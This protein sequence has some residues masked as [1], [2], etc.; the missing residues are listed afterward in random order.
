M[1]TSSHPLFGW[2][3][4]RWPWISL[5]LVGLGA[6]LLGIALG[7]SD[8]P[9]DSRAAADAA[10][11]AAEQTLWTCSM[12]PQVR[13]SQP[14]KCPI[15]GM[16]LIRA[17][18]EQEGT[19]T[20]PR[21]ITLSERAKTLARIRTTEARRRG[22]EGQQQQLS[23]RVTYDETRLKTV[24]AW[25][26]GRIDRLHVEVTG[27][28]V[29]AGQVIATLYSPE[30]YAAH[31]DLL[32]TK[33][34][35][36]AMQS[37]NADGAA[38]AESALGA[39]RKRLALLGVPSQTIDRMQS[40]DA[41]WEHINIYS[42]FTGTVTQRIASEGRYVDAGSPLYELADLRSVW[43]QLDAYESDLPELHVGQAVTLTFQGLPER[44]FT[45]N[46][47][48]IDP[49]V[50]PQERT[51][52]VRVE[53]PNPRGDIRPGMFAEATL[54]AATPK[55]TDRPLVIP[56]SAPLFTG[57][58]AVV[59]VEVPNAPRPT[60]A[61]RV[62]KLGP[63]TGELYPVLAGLRAGERVVTHGAFVLDA[64]LQIRGGVSMMSLPDDTEPEPLDAV[65]P[66]P[67]ALQEDLGAV[68]QHYLKIQKA[69][70]ADDLAAARASG[71]QLMRSIAAVRPE[72]EP[73]KRA[74]SRLHEPFS[75]AAKRLADATQIDNARQHFFAL[76]TTTKTLLRTFGNPLDQ[77]IR[78]AH[79]PMARDGRGADWLQT[80]ET[81]D[82]AYFGA[83][84][85]TC[86][87]IE[88]SLPPGA[89]LTPEGSRQT[90]PRGGSEHQH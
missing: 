64:D 21:Q 79:C 51:A 83:E 30:I 37:A 49:V 80:P 19:G 20:N 84:M 34:Y 24:T 25:T 2:F 27:A 70:A 47:A 14:G 77:P 44:E 50:D 60:Y 40:A 23:G 39:A 56:R 7:G 57:R 90:P 61:L 45:G 76:S 59:Y 74:W 54:Q 15:C 78:V 87:E 58:R 46:I 33:R 8:A 3:R 63:K 16:D 88:Q 82:N 6:F 89:Y 10:S 85:P 48:F 17:R 52:R 73:A 29:A 81:I 86:G 4:R 62:V 13:Q 35:A 36:D 42:P 41:P 1:T 65:L 67:K 53:V 72:S 71:T 31:Q 66:T 22:L 68:L 26:R 5:P 75:R 32:A 69:L 55:D 38:A 43:V 11:S 18:T 9:T 28:T 12:H